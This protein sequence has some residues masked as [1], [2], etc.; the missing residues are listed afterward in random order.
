[1]KLLVDMSLS[2]RWVDLLKKAG[3][4]A[5]HRSTIGRTIAR[6]T[7][8]MAWAAANKHVVLTQDMD[9]GGVLAA[10]QGIN[11]SVVQTSLPIK[12]AYWGSRDVHGL[13]RVS[14][15][16]LNLDMQREA[17]AKAGFQRVFEGKTSGNRAERPTLT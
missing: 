6:D 7:E 4:E 9:F 15:R 12:P 8:I 11:P 5:V 2:P 16:D 3:L 13:R 17:L 10:A 1:M 14:T